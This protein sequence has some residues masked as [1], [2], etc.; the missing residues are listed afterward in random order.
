MHGGL[1]EP[2]GGGKWSRAHVPIRDARSRA[3]VCQRRG[4][5]G[6]QAHPVGQLI[7]GSP[8]ARVFPAQQ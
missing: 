8:G 1:A 7:P 3:G 6:P 2:A 4:P 5:L